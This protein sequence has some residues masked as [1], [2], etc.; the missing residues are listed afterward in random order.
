MVTENFFYY[1]GV[2]TASYAVHLASNALYSFLRPSSLP[3]YQHR[4]KDSW[5]LITGASDGIG[6]GFAEELSA[7]GFNVILHGR[8]RQKLEKCAAK[9]AQNFPSRKIRLIVADASAGSITTDELLKLTGDIQLTILINNVGGTHPLSVPFKSLE[10]YTHDEIDKVI[11]LNAGFTTQ[12]T[13][14]LLPALIRNGP[15]LILNIGSLA[16]LAGPWIPVYAGTKGYLLSY[17]TGLQTELQAD[18]KDVTVHA[19][20]VGA[21]STN[22]FKVEISLFVPSARVEAQVTLDKVG[23]GSVLMTPFFPHAL[24]KF[25]LV[26]APQTLVRSM[27]IRTMKAIKN[28]SSSDMKKV[29]S[30]LVVEA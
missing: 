18:G 9:L 19:A 25:F 20:L 13:K 12:I 17:S 3:R 23:C 6:Y 1:T 21:V 15:S 22:G 16:Y 10:E 29:E 7:R 27:I 5:A 26:N 4:P 2:V 14:T 30:F 24:Q 11:N 8:N 28:E